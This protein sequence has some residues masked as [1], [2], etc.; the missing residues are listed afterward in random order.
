MPQL[1][2]YRHRAMHQHKTFIHIFSGK[3]QLLQHQGCG[4]KFWQ[5]KHWSLKVAFGYGAN[6]SKFNIMHPKVV[7]GFKFWHKSCKTTQNKISPEIKKVAN[8]K[9]NN[10]Q[11]R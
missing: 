10:L 11:S 3:E 2:A 6:P 8:R 9:V 4:F 7:V 1:Y 5:N